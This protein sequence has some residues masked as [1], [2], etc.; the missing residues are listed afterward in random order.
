MTVEEVKKQFEKYREEGMS[1]DEIAVTLYLMFQKD[2]M[3]AEEFAEL[4]DILGYEVGD[5]FLNATPEEQKDESRWFESVED[6][7]GEEGEEEPENTDK[8]PETEKEDDEE[9]ARKLFGL[10]QK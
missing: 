5:E 10:E 2:V 1:D 8:E 4:M 7:E 3:N 6:E 9:K